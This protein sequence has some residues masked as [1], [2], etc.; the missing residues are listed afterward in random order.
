MNTFA[1]V[2]G[3]NYFG[4]DVMYSGIDGRMLKT[5]VYQGMM[6]YQRLKPMTEDNYQVT[7]FF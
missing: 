4:E 1:T 3:F 6:Y 7:I 2:A 5:H